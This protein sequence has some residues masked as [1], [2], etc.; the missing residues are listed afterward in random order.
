MAKARNLDAQ[1]EHLLESMRLRAK[2][3]IVTVY[4]DAI[5]PHGGTAWLGSVIKLVEPFGLSERIVRTSVFRLSKDDW[6]TSRQI[7]RRSYYSM[8][9]SGRHRTEAVHRRIYG[10]LHRPWNGE[11]CVVSATN[12]DGAE[13]ERLRRDLGWMGFGAMAQ[14][15]FAHPSPDHEALRQVLQDL[16]LTERVVVMRASSLSSTQALRNLVQ[17]CWDLDQLAADYNVFLDHFR[18]VWRAL[19]SAR[20][21]DPRYCFLIR[22]LLIHDFRRLILRDPMLPD[23]LLPTDWSGTASRILC[24]N[25]YRVALEPAERH[26]M[27]ILETADGPLPEAAP[28]FFDRFGRLAEVQEAG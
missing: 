15:V 26:L 28:H 3:L 27:S 16:E 4:G 10:P 11:W 2:S 24:R 1:V 21:L 22:I 17:N 6:L 5:L 12:C 19:E 23:E 14:S 13:R 25:I 20:E 8:T 9:E 7:G 18:P